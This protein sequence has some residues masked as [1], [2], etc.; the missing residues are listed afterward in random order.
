MRA[1]LPALLVA[2]AFPAAA[3]PLTPS[4]AAGRRIYHEGV[5]PSGREIEAQVGMSHA[6]LPGPAVACGNCHGPDGVGRPEAGVDPS[7]LTWSHLTKSYGHVHDNGRR[8]PAYDEASF[9][10]AITAGID[11][12][13]NVLEPA[14]PRYA[15]H[16]EDMRDLVAYMKRL[17][18]DVD[19]GVT[20]RTVRVGT[21]LP[22]GAG[23]GDAMRE[24]IE[25]AFDEVNASGGL[26]G[27]RVELVVRSFVPGPHSA[28]VAARDLLDRDG[29]FAIVSPFAL[30]VEGELAKLGEERHVPV[31][32]PFTI[33]GPAGPAGRYTFYL[34]GGLAEQAEVLVSFGVRYTG[35]AHEPLAIVHPDEPT[36]IAAARAAES[37]CGMR[38]CAK[39]GTVAYRP[40]A[41]DAA[42]VAARCR[43]MGAAAV[44]FLGPAPD[45]ERFAK[46]AD[47]VRWHPA[48]LSPGMLAGRAASAVPP[49]F[50]ERV[51]LAY[52]MSPSRTDGGSAFDRFA[53]KHRL[54]GANALPAFSGYVAASLFLDG[55]RRAGRDVSREKLV[56]HLESTTEYRT[57]LAQPLRY[58]P[59]RRIGALGGHVVT[60]S[61]DAKAMRPA[62]GWISLD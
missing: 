62:S 14:M 45:F 3:Q 48:L 4:E 20:D 60:P 25:A 51:Y 18:R 49:G 2:A 36:A 37:R 10:R 34:F 17:E 43:D 56:E 11:P 29:V 33:R 13:G 41:F 23:A 58:G 54:S 28:V 7:L 8:H 31:V 22:A 1:L 39:A 40:D 42:G 55:L 30:G 15:L 32:G 27:R 46:A 6:T 44:L 52:P 24:A 53:A 16:A 50:A 47:A 35:L 5:S 61:A 38:A 21:V 19:A 9:A 59:Q 12:A 57:P 26:Y